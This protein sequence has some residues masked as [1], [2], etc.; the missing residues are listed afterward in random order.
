[1]PNT[2]NSIFFVFVFLYKNTKWIS[3]FCLDYGFDRKS[4]CVFL[5]ENSYVEKKSEA[6]PKI[7]AVLVG[8]I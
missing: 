2:E 4:V 7:L 8:V 6:K 5:Y 1:M 3:F